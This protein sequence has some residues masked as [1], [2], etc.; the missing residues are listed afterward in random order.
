MPP[1][2]GFGVGGEGFAISLKRILLIILLMS[3]TLSLTQNRKYISKRISPIYQQNKVVINLLLLFFAVKVLSLTINSREI[4]Q[5]IMLFM[6]FLSS[7]FIM[8]LTIL[9]INTKES[10]NH[11]AKIIFYSYN[12]VLILVLIEYILQYPVYGKLAS[13]Q[14]MLLTDATTGLVRGG[15][16]RVRASFLNSIVLGQYLVMLSPI[17]LA[18][19]YKNNY[20]LLKKIIY[21]LF[22][23]FAVYTTGSRSSILMS[24]LL[25]YLYFMF[26][27]WKRGRLY[28]FIIN[29]LNLIIISTVFSFIY[30]FISGL[31]SNFHGRF[32]LLGDEETISSTSRAL[33]Y[34]RIYDQMHEAPFFGF[35]RARNYTE[36][37]GSSIDNYYFWTILEVGI[38]G[39][40]IYL[41]FLYFS[42]KTAVK[43]YKL[44]YENY[45]ILPIMIAIL[46]IIS[47]MFLI[48][49][50]D[51]HVYLYIFAGLISVMKVLQSNKREIT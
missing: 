2:L 11:L 23:I 21:F 1:Y 18:Y 20:S 38:I 12:I 9:L 37:V 47:S 27:L 17:I 15:M 22:F 4:S 41:L 51:N 16:H 45:Y 25:V 34:I 19:M 10:I 26:V 49:A 46:I 7:I 28:K 35:G 43:L 50:P 39:I 32:D 29:L 31:I 33:Q 24:L 48:Q 8:M 13:D 3:L 6:D 42:I 40:T 30:D 44:S 36:M 5:Y 14:M